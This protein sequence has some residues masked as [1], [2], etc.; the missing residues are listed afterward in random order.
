MKELG[1]LH[2]TAVGWISTTNSELRTL[3]K[4]VK[5]IATTQPSTSSK[6]L[7]VDTASYKPND[8]TEV[9]SNKAFY[10]APAA[11]NT[12]QHTQLLHSSTAVSN[13]LD[14]VEAVYQ[15]LL[16]SYHQ[17]ILVDVCN[18][19]AFKHVVPDLEAANRR[20][21]RN[22]PIDEMHANASDCL[23]NVCDT[24]GKASSDLIARQLDHLRPRMHRE[25]R[26]YANR[27][28]RLLKYDHAFH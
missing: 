9:R 20:T 15:N 22:Y 11:S 14:G 8:E 21:R 4:G 23:E 2:D 26:D 5:R 1:V 19:H 6:Q 16:S 25:L 27:Q 7:K 3:V 13:T 18:Y 17:Q 10:N 24:F 12:T 28:L